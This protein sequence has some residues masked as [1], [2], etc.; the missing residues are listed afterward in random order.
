MIN[1]TSKRIICL[2][3]AIMMLAS[4]NAV[5]AKDT[6][7]SVGIKNVIYM[8]PDGGGMGSFYL[9][10]E[11]KK[12]GGFGRNFPNAT[13][14]DEGEMYIKPYLVGAEMTYAA[15]VAVTDSA[16]AG[17]ALSSGYK[18]NKT[19]VGISPDKKPH[20]NILEACQELGKKTGIVV[21]FE[22]TNA[23]PATFSAHAETRYE[24]LNIAT[25]V[26]NQGIDVVFG[27]THSDYLPEKWFTDESFEERGYDVIKTMEDL[28][29]IKAGDRV[30][31]KLPKAYYDT[32]IDADTPNLAE[33]TEAAIR[34][35]DDGSEEGFF[36]M[37][38]GSAVDKGGE[39]NDAPDTVG[40]FLAF[41]AACKVAIEYAKNRNDTMVVILPDHDSGGATYE[42]ADI[43]E[44]VKNTKRGINSG[45]IT[46]ESAGH[47]ARDGG[48]FMYIP[49]WAEYPEGIDIEKA[50]E[51]ATAFEEN[52]GEC[53]VN[54]VENTTIAQYIAGLLG[55]DLNLLTEDLFVDVTD[56]GEY[57]FGT[58]SFTFSSVTGKKVE[59]A[60]NASVATIDREEVSLDG[61]IAL[62]LDGKF[63]VPNALINIIENKATT[64]DPEFIVDK[65]YI[66]EEYLEKNEE[67]EITD[68]SIKGHW[69][70]KYLAKAV[71]DG[72]I[73]GSDKGLEPDRNVTKAELITMVMRALKIENDQ[74]AGPKW[75]SYAA[76]KA[77]ELGWTASV[78]D[79]E[80]AINRAAS[81]SIIANAKNIQVEMG[82]GKKFEDNAEI[83]ETGY[84]GAVMAC[85][86]KGIITGY[87]D[88]TFKPLN[89]I[90]RAEAVVI[91]QRAFY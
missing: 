83:K 70:E 29:N 65:K 47:T 88:N 37:V 81:A 82:D 66:K 24:T 46:W 44:I 39:A 34:A 32:D 20:A 87:P 3:L 25:Q 85:V 17:T 78:E 15:D 45:K 26:I 18:T 49:E 79:I 91:I 75:Y 14:V 21:T 8:I 67:P 5:F 12:A 27:E 73:K 84:L 10:N 55:I 90:T 76:S 19:Y 48:I 1:K 7:S 72:L 56:M 2:L 11:V 69:A 77:T 59:I 16:A 40:E 86:Q 31:G 64:E 28:E 68:P 89:T 71:S 54:L 50:P 36:L 38:E 60:K 61:R 63:Y 33:L 6:E 62:Y 42:E 22:W 51:V 13:Q 9:A 52:P 4:V 80:L 30:W 53:N 35:L 23:T 57:N 74:N 43:E 41:D 58:E